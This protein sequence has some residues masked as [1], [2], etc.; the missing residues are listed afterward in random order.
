MQTEEIAEKILPVY[1]AIQR[2]HGKDYSFASQ[3]TILKLLKKHR[4]WTR[5]RSTLNRWLRR[6]EDGRY[7]NRIR[8]MRRDPKVGTVFQTTIV[9][10]LLK[11]YH[12]VKK[13]GMNVFKEIKNLIAKLEK[14]YP[15]FNA[16][17]KG[18]K[19]AEEKKGNG[20]RGWVKNQIKNSLGSLLWSF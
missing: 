11:G 1:L 17:S 6:L 12:Q 3:D 10:I 20:F 13:T 2:K 9:Q 19:I 16:G 14:K 5:S 18:K 8:R 15:E 7:I 4:G